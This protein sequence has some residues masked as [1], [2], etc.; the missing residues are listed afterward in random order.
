[1]AEGSADAHYHCRKC[2]L[3]YPV[4]ADARYC[5]HRRYGGL[6]ITEC[7]EAGCFEEAL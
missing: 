3:A 7:T 1:M 6:G 5:C 4:R 2:G